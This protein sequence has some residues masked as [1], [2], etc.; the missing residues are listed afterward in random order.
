M[1]LITSISHRFQKGAGC[2]LNTFKS[3]PSLIA[4]YCGDGMNA[5]IVFSTCYLP[6][7][8]T[9]DYQYVMDNLFRLVSVL[10]WGCQTAGVCS[11]AGR[12]GHSR[13]A[14]CVYFEVKDTIHFHSCIVPKVNCGPWGFAFSL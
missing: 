13:L 8:T 9:K 4:G 12:C 5:V 1:S 3:S 7:N 10:R 2:S 14:E 6:E 11:Q